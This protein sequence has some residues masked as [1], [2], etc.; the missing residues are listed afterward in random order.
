MNP[1]EFLKRAIEKADVRSCDITH[2][3]YVD[4]VDQESAYSELYEALE[5]LQKASAEVLLRDMQ[6]NR[7][8][9]A[10]GELNMA[11][12]I[13]KAALAHARGEK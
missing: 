3:A 13:A 4:K 10:L 11:A 1:R 8:D 12:F 2:G 9:Q 7:S 6:N 5:R